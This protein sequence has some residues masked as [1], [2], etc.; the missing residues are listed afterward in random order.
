MQEKM[1]TFPA[2]KKGPPFKLTLGKGEVIR[3]WEIGLQGMKV[4]GE[5]RITIPAKLAYG[6]KGM[7]GIPPNSDLVFD[8]KLIANN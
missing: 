8:L 1:L 5:R 4:G 6:K 3:G 7:P 2:N